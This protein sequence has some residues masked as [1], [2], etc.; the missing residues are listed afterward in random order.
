M[1]RKRGM[2]IESLCRVYNT[3]TERVGEV[4]ISGVYLKDPSEVYK[5]Y[6]QQTGNRV[7]QVLKTKTNRVSLTMDEAEF[8]EKATVKVGEEVTDND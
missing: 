6:E 3:S 1:I 7:V 2:Q 5:R 8:F 4:A